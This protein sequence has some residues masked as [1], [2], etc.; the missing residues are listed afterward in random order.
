MAEYAFVDFEGLQYYDAKLKQKLSNPKHSYTTAA[1]AA[2]NWYRLANANVSQTDVSTPLHTQFILTAYNSGQDTGYWQRWFVDAQVYGRNAGI[3]IFGNTAVPFSQARVLYENTIADIDAN[4]RPAIDLY[5]NYV[6]ANAATVITVEELYNSGWTFPAD[7]ALAAS[8]VP[9]GFENV[10]SS[11]RNNGVERSTYADYVSYLN[12]QVSAITAAFTLADSYLYRSRTLNCTGT[13]TITVPN[14]NSGYMWCVVKNANAS[15]GVITIHPST[16]SVLIDGSNADITL[17]PQEYVCIHSKGANA[18][19]IIG[20]GRWISKKADKATTLA[21]YG[22]AD[23]KIESGTITL[24]TA[25][26]TPLTSHQSLANYVT[27]DGAQTITGAKTFTASPSVSAGQPITVLSNSS[28]TKGTNPSSAV[29]G[30]IV[31]QDKTTAVNMVKRGGS[32]DFSVDANGQTSAAIRAFNWGVEDNTNGAISIYY[33]KNGTPYTA[34]PT[35][36]VADNSTKIATT[37]WARTA[38]GNFACNAATAT[39]ASSLNTNGNPSTATKMYYTVGQPGL[40]TT[41]GKAF[42]GSSND[43]SLLSFPENGTVSTESTANIQNIRMMWASSTTYFTDI[44]VSPNN[45]YVWHRD[46]MNNNAFGWRRMV[47]EDV[48]GIAAPTW[49]ISIAGTATKATQDA[50]GNVITTT[51]AT[52]SELADIGSIS[53]AQIDALF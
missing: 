15:S 9:T 42:K 38:T 49:N 43:A 14:I 6:M 16:T 24:G 27:L 51:Y 3:R 4:D 33:P 1:S 53:T 17:Q 13:F 47:E 50:S 31:F 18:Y 37:A 7:G 8:T 28:L 30:N 35:P 32:L 45:H 23:A 10:A 34:V 41:A 12:R 2:K 40:G 22:I 20:D 26:I 39:A 11:V 21:G 44:F 19:S 46:V 5:L 25:T 36:A 29:Y 52:K 48:T